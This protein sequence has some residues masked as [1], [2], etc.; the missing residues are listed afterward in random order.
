VT[1][2]QAIELRQQQLNGK[3]VDPFMAE[4]ALRVIMESGERKAYVSRH[5]REFLRLLS[6]NGAI[7]HDEA[8]KKIS[9]KRACAS[10]KRLVDRGLV[11]SEI[12]LTEAGLRALGLRGPQT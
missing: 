10:I 5:Q 2:D 9:A 11:K 6:S 8:H 4:V 1:L 12:K 3:S 7:D